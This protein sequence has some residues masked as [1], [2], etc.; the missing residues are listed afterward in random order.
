MNLLRLANRI[1]LVGGSVALIAVASVLLLPVI[2]PIG[3]RPI[4]SS[5]MEPAIEAGALVVS[6]EV[7]AA[8]LKVG[9]V[10]SFDAPDGS[11]EFVTRRI[12]AVE[13]GAASAMLR[14]KG[15]ALP[16][17]DPWAL[18]A[19]GEIHRLSFWI[20]YAGTVL[21]GL[22]STGGRLLTALIPLAVVGVS[23]LVESRILP[24]FADK[25]S[26]GA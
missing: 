9:R 24:A 5:A 16:A 1:V 22:D 14:T 13:P 18:P 6:R 23:L 25:R 20:P 12:T 26:P 3:I 7:D 2:L 21:G 10:I 8:G 17:P 11:H 15:D 4:D 19:I